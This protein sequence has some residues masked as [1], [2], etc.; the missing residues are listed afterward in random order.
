MARCHRALEGVFE[1]LER[2]ILRVEFKGFM[3]IRQS[4]CERNDSEIR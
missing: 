2:L 4:V 3:R 1:S